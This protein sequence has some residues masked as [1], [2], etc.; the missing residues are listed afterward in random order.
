MILLSFF[1]M[2][3]IKKVF[4]TKETVRLGGGADALHTVLQAMQKELSNPIKTGA[5][6][7]GRLDY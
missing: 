4:K 6:F 5:V 2:N 1:C 7:A 3:S